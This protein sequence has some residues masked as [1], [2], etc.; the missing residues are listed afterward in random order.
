[1]VRSETVV[2]TVGVTMF[3]AGAI[4]LFFSAVQFAAAL[5]SAR[6][7]RFIVHVGLSYFAFIFGLILSLVG[8]LIWQAE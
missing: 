5:F 7:I 3:A 8:F 1:M 2:K 4:L 6:F